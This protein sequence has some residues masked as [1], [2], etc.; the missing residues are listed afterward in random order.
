MKRFG[1]LSAFIVGCALSAAQAQAAEPDVSNTGKGIAGGALLGAEV[2]TATEAFIGV[3]PNWW[4]AVGAGAGASAG[5][6]GGYFLESRLSEKTTMIGLTAG[7]LL[8]IPTTVLVL[9][10]AAEKLPPPPDEDLELL[11]TTSPRPAAPR[12]SSAVGV[13]ERGVALSVPLP[14][15]HDV[16]T[17]QERSM[18]GLSAATEW[19]F[20]LLDYTF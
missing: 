19:R 13:D 4:Y 3:K 20:G 5:G 1:L 10:A 2:V 14:T 16:Y 17:P 15:V 7:M 8:V 11:A 9:K 18:Y 6:V 12:V